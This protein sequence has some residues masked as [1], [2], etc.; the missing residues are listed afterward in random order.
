MNPGIDRTLVIL[1]RGGLGDLLCGTPV[2]E[3]LKSRFPETEI[4]AM[5]RESAAPLLKG[6]PVIRD[7]I[8]TN[9]KDLDTIPGFRKSLSEIRKKNFNRAI[10]LWSKA[11]EAWLVR[12]AGIPV[13]VGQD[14]RLAYSFNYTHRVRVRSEHGD[15]ESHWADILLD[16]ARALGIKAKAERLFLYVDDNEKQKARDFL[17]N[18]GLP[19]DEPYMIF[20]SGKGIPITPKNWPVK[21]FSKLARSL[22]E[23]TSL[24]VL[25]TGTIGELEA[26]SAIAESAGDNMYNICG[27]TDIRLLC[28]LVSSSSLLLCPDSGP[29][30]IA[31]ALKIPTIAL[32]GLKSD[33]PNRWRPLGTRHRILV[34]D[35]YRCKKHCIK[36]KCKYFV[37]YEGITPE[38]VGNAAMSLLSE[39][40]A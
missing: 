26:V 28:G 19:P 23:M 13:R 6:N 12:L 2:F 16:Y 30:H 32:F 11:P 29:M 17:K 1:A 34:P 18:L 21:H 37:C 35:D 4:T 9:D 14:S 3:A 33:F 10:I 8:K 25:L 20:H 27:K 39:E 31:A 15:T 40:K 38:S 5:V 22:H 24:P 7:V 36:E